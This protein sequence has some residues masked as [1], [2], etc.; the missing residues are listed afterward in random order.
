MLLLNLLLHDPLSVRSASKVCSG[1]NSKVKV[2]EVYKP[3]CPSAK[4]K[5]NLTL[6]RS[7]EFESCHCL[8]HARA[9]SP[10]FPLSAQPTHL[11]SINSSPCQY[12]DP[13]PSSTFG[14]IVVRSVTSQQ[15]LDHLCSLS[16]FALIAANLQV[17]T[18]S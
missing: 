17:L 16:L 2:T 6:S 18:V 11:L 7:Y 5:P 1:F 8:G 10:R 9:S 4:A 15:L 14:Q 13:D 12:T 3:L